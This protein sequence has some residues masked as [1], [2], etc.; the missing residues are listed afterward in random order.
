MKPIANLA[1]RRQRYWTEVRST[2]GLLGFMVVQASLLCIFTAM[3][4]EIPTMNAALVCAALMGPP[5]WFMWPNYPSIEDVERDRS[6]RRSAGIADDV[7][8]D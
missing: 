6:L 2:I 7:E 8:F 1:T 4:L 3:F 5:I